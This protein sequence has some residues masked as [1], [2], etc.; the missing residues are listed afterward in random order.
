[1]RA[2]M[3]SYL[4]KEAVALIDRTFF[5]ADFA[6]R[7]QKRASGEPYIIH[8]I[9][10]ATVIVQMHLDVESVQ[11]ALLHDVVEDTFI[12][13]DMLEQEFGPTVNE[14]VDGVT[15]LDKLRFHDYKEAQMENFRKM[16]LAMTKDIRVILIKLADRTHNMRTLGA[17]RPDKRVRIAKETLDVFVPIA[18]RLG[19]SDIRAE[20]EELCMAS[21]YPMRYRVLKAAV[22]RARNNRKE[23]VSSIQEA[24]KARLKE[25][26]IE[27]RVLGREKRIFSIYKKMVHKE[28]QFREIM[29]VYGF[30][31]ILKDVDTCYRVLGQMHNLFKPRPNGFKDYIAIPKLNGYQSLHTSL[32][33]PHG[34]PIEIQIRT[35]L[36]DQMAARGVAAHWAYKENGSKAVSTASQ[37]NAQDWIKNLIDL[38]QSAGSSLEFVEDVKTDLFPDSIFVFTPDGMIYNLPKGATPVDFAYALHTDIG[39]HCIGARVNHHA[40]PLSRSLISGQTIEIITSPNASPNAIWLST[41]VTSRARSS[42]RQYLKG[43]RSQECQLIG[44]R[45]LQ[46]ALRSQKLDNLSDET[47]QNILINFKEPDLNALYSDIAMGNIL[48][49]AVAKFLD[50]NTHNHHELPIKGTGGMPFTFAQ[51]CMPIPGDDIIAHIAQGRGIVIHTKNCKNLRASD[52]GPGKSLNVSWNYAITANMDFKTGLL[53]EIENRQGIVS[54][55]SNAIDVASSRIESINSDLKDEKTFRIDLV[56]AVRDRLHLASVIKHLRKVPNILSIHRRK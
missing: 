46:N 3:C 4:P 47:I 48:T 42:I 21:I 36:M 55:I 20:L 12:T 22:T 44:R 17:L 41:V 50:P 27:G 26:K 9:A 37:K 16:I 52:L 7:E 40:F 38:Q 10:V 51:C 54:E 35:E 32:I 13:S 28:L 5:V 56:I 33:G 53:I 11:A 31:I 6:H 39:N 1:M 29:D 15:K 19:I 23:V 2:L 25:A 49:V 30:R 8:P 34:V 24:I 43:L 18:N 45:L 14:I